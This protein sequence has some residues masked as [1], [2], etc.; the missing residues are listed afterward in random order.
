MLPL[1]FRCTLTG[2]RE[3]ETK[4]RGLSPRKIPQEVR[5]GNAEL[6]MG[7]CALIAHRRSH[8]LALDPARYGTSLLPAC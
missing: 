3:K 5:R 2:M 7:I 4:Q 1:P 8:A 6:G